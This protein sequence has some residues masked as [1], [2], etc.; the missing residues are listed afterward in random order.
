MQ[1]GLPR[2]RTTQDICNN[3]YSEI[4]LVTPMPLSHCRSA[5]NLLSCESTS[6]P[7]R[8]PRSR[9]SPVTVQEEQAAF[10]QCSPTDG[11]TTKP[12]PG[13][14][15]R[16]SPPTD[17]VQ[18][19]QSP[20]EG[21]QARPRA[22]PRQDVQSCIDTGKQI[23]VGPPEALVRASQPVVP[24]RQHSNIVTS[25]EKTVSAMRKS[26]IGIP[27]LPQKC[28]PGDDGRTLLDTSV[29]IDTPEPDPFDT[30]TIPSHHIGPDPP[31]PSTLPPV[32][33]RPPMN[34][35]NPN[36]NSES[37]PTS[38]VP[39]PPSRGPVGPPHPPPRGDSGSE[40]MTAV[41]PPVPARPGLSPEPVECN[42]IPKQSYLP[43][44]PAR[45]NAPPPVPPRTDM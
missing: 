16:Q 38:G 15:S 27:V 41:L 4:D 23:P 2:S 31:Q 19:R 11:A 5:E 45:P 25:H 28:S 39:T 44:V 32:P 14:I 35:H 13:T 36:P 21:V 7:V 40:G 6:A 29:S 37:S 9:D 18:T 20:T 17:V 42:G 12:R 30:S 26:G 8:P 24:S 34:I 10:R 43:P 22:R 1:T 33:H 3:V